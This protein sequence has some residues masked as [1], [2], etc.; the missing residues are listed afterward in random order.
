[1]PQ[2]IF[3]Q[4][5]LCLVCLVS[6]Y[7]WWPLT[8]ANQFFQM[9]FFGQESAKFFYKRSDRKYFSISMLYSLFVTTEQFYYSTKAANTIINECAVSKFIYK[10]NWWAEFS[11]HFSWPVQLKDYY[12]FS[13]KS[14]VSI[15]EFHGILFNQSSICRIESLGHDTSLLFDYHCIL[16]N[17]L[18]EYFVSL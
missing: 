6:F 11:P 4:F 15:G 18:L 16:F 10:R 8:F 1:M 12:I 9:Y 2:F 17:T 13:F 3:Q 14:P 5:L 7:Y